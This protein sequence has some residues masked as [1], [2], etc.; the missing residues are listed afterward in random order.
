M[1][2]ACQ[3]IIFCFGLMSQL[4]IAHKIKWGYLFSLASQPFWFIVTYSHRQWGMFALVIVHTL[5]VIRAIQVWFRRDEIQK[6]I[7]ANIKE[8]ESLE[9]V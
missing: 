3:V 8:S 1:D 5:I 6:N 7:Q 2:I 4:L 9:V